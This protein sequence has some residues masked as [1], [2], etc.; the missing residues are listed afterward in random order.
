MLLKGKHIV[1][2]GAAGALGES[3]TR[4]AISHGAI[5]SELDIN[6]SEI[7]KNRHSVDLKDEE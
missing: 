7:T 6:F 2:T 5:V 1:I 3:A 4:I